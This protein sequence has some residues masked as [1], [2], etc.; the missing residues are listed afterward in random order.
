M[1]P[2]YSTTCALEAL[3][4]PKEALAAAVRL[5]AAADPP[6]VH[7]SCDQ[8]QR[9]R[10]DTGGA[11]LGARFREHSHEEIL[12]REFARES[13]IHFVVAVLLRKI[14]RRHAVEC[15]PQFGW[16]SILGILWCGT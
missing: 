4:F 8:V 10:S 7:A 13:L 6:C 3:A 14:S 5:A 12:G 11:Y 16:V 1:V 2:F 9:S 15:L